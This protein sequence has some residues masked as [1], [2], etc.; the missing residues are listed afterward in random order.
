MSLVQFGINLRLTNSSISKIFVI[1]PNK[2]NSKLFDKM[3]LNLV[4]LDYGSFM[5]LPRSYFPRNDDTL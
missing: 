3:L 1:N 4:F 5:R 2:L